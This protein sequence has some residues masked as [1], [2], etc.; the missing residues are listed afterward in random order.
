M[1]RPKLPKYETDY[2]VKTIDKFR[3]ANTLPLVQDLMLQEGWTTHLFD[4]AKNDEALSEALKRVYLKQQSA[5]I[6]G[7]LTG[8]LDKT[9][10][11]FLLKQ[12]QHGFTDRA[13]VELTG[14]L[15]V[16]ISGEDDL[17]D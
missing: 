16:V 17:E 5:Y 7:G 13:S 3:E 11:I 8:N 12:R 4:L 15:P 2:M 1:A 14:E 9:M 6:K 10:V